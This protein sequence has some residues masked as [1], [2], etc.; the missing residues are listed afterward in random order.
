[1]T[2]PAQDTE[3]ITDVTKA[4]SDLATYAQQ[5]GTWP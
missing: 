5:Q 4:D 2:T 3:Y 1:M